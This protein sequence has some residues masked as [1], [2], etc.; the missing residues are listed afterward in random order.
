MHRM[1]HGERVG[2]S[3]RNHQGRRAGTR[4]PLVPHRWRHMVP[5]PTVLVVDDDH[6]GV[7]AA[8][9]AGHRLQQ[10]D[11]G[12]RPAHGTTGSRMLVVAVHELHEAD[13]GQRAT[14][15][16]DG[17]GERRVVLQVLAA[18]GPTSRGL[19]AECL[20]VVEPL[21]VKLELVVG[22]V[23]ELRTR[24]CV[25]VGALAL[26]VRPAR[27]S[28]QTRGVG[29]PLGIPGPRHPGLAEPTAYG[30]PFERR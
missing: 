11:R 22:A 6:H 24:P 10:P 20:E 13:P 27:L 15:T 30:G 12:L 5:C 9:G 21:M 16:P 26:A 19:R 23:G 1:V 29:P 28:L 7:L 14:G 8:R 18:V 25:R 3:R 17:L 2:Q 4:T